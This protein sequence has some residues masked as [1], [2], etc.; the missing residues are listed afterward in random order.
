MEQHIIG[1]HSLWLPI[2]LSSVAVF[3]LSSILHM[4]TPWHKSDYSKIENQ[5]KVMDAFRSMNLPAGDYAVPMPSSPQDMKSPEFTERM[6]KGPLAVF[7][8]RP[9][10]PMS[11]SKNLIQWFLYSVV[12]G[13]FVAYVTGRIYTHGAPYLQVFRLAGTTAFLSYSLAL[14][15]FSIWYSRNWMTT[16]KSMFDGLVYAAATAAVFAWLWP[17]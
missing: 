9:G 15:Q 14:A 16:F 5:D 1:I 2:L 6:M 10:Q 8:L 4:F 11:M 7:T 12:V 3:I 17:L 13:I